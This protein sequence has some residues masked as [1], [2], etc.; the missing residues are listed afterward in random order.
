M[1]R[2]QPR[3]VCLLGRRGKTST[4]NQNEVAGPGFTLLS[5]TAIKC[6]KYMKPCFSNIGHQATNNSGPWE[7]RTNEESPA[8]VPQTSRE[9]F[10]ALAWGERTQAEPGVS[11]VWGDRPRWVQFTSQRGEGYIERIPKNPPSRGQLQRNEAPARTTLKLLRGNDPRIMHTPPARA[12]S[13]EVFLIVG[14]KEP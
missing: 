11:Y 13:L 2:K 5:G 1:S 3:P 12:G 10:Q 14:Q 8:I 9:S 4:S 7:V 6:M